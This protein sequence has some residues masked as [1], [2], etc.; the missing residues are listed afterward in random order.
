MFDHECCA[1]FLLTVAYIYAISSLH[2][3]AD[4]THTVREFVVVSSITLHHQLA[5]TCRP[6]SQT[7]VPCSCHAMVRICGHTFGALCHPLQLTT[8][9][10]PVPASRWDRCNESTGP[11][12]S[13][14]QL[15][16]PFHFNIS[17]MSGIH[18]IPLCNKR[19]TLFIHITYNSGKCSFVNLANTFQGLLNNDCHWS[20]HL[21]DCL[22]SA[23][24]I[25][26]HR[27]LSSLTKLEYF[28]PTATFKINFDLGVVLLA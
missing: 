2:C 14:P 18:L 12:L 23:W 28:I 20:F 21:C 7:S 1:R 13:R 4:V 11:N 9:G 26:N 15:I 17:Q 16:P 22:L 25:G 10:Q 27:A 24:T 5:W 19:E 6:C 3:L 8:A